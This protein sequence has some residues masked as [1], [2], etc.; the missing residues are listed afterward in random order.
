MFVCVSSTKK[1]LWKDVK[2]NYTD[3]CISYKKDKREYNFHLLALK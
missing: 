2:T 1:K 3:Y